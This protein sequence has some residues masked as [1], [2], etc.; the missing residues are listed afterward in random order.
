MNV[1]MIE[2]GGLHCSYFMVVCVEL[3]LLFLV[4]A[5]PS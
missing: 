5:E 2:K 3:Y 1:I 4:L